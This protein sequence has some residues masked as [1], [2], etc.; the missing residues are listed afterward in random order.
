[1]KFP[2][3]SVETLLV[4]ANP[5]SFYTYPIPDAEFDL[6]NQTMD[7]NLRHGGPTTL[8]DIRTPAY[9]KKQ[10]TV[11]NRQVVSIVGAEDLD[12]LA[13]HLEL[14]EELALQGLLRRFDTDTHAGV[15]TGPGYT[16]TLEQATGT[17]TRLFLAQCL[18]A[19]MVVSDFQGTHDTPNF[20]SL[21]RGI[22]VGPYDEATRK[23]TPDGAT[24]MITRPNPPCIGPG[25]LIE[26]TYGSSGGECAKAF[27]KFGQGRRGFVSMVSKGGQ[28]EVGQALRF[29]PYGE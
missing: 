8:A 11:L 16:A 24:V 10:D 18:G 9:R 26:A 29:I 14:D 12:Y 28:M 17:L 13:D 7:G 2:A 25:K 5:D 27:V 6:A 21:S 3:G 20:R 23:F 15:A 4:G 19:N 22:D 1:M